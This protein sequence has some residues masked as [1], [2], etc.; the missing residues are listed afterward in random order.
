MLSALRELAARRLKRSTARRGKI[1]FHLP[2]EHFCENPA[3]RQM[4][5]DAL[6]P[7]RVRARGYFDAAEVSRLVAGMDGGDFVAVKKVMALVILELWH[8][9]FVDR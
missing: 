8:Q 6:S 1:P 4:V 3:L 2:I 7:E 5:A 9:T